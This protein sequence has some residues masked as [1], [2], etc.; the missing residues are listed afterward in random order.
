M[1][2]KEA[3]KFIRMARAKAR[4]DRDDQM[5]GLKSD[6]E[7][8]SANV[9]DSLIDFLKADNRAE[10]LQDALFRNGSLDKTL[11]FETKTIKLSCCSEVRYLTLKVTDE[12]LEILETLLAA[13]TLDMDMEETLRAIAAVR[14]FETFNAAANFVYGQLGLVTMD[15]ELRTPGILEAL[16]RRVDDFYIDFGVDQIEETKRVILEEF[17]AHGRGPINPSFYTRI[18]ETSGR[19]A[20]WQAV[21]FARTE[22][23]VVQ[24]LAHKEVYT[25]NQVPRKR[26]ITTYSEDTR[27]HGVAPT[28][29]IPREDYFYVNG[30]YTW[31]PLLFGVAKEDINCKCDLAPDVDDDFELDEQPWMG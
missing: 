12:E 10:R 2:L 7:T 15:F 23:G 16:D 21:R 6:L 27:H 20:G 24:M 3:Q 18:A 29:P 30:H 28:E 9:T 17:I 1:A 8:F 26:W 4:F 22:T 5:Q 11:E 19:R 25:R 14:S 13:W 31:G